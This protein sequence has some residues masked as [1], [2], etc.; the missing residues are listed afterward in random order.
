MFRREIH[1]RA[2]VKVCKGH[3]F[4]VKRDKK[5][6]RCFEWILKKHVRPP[7]QNDAKWPRWWGSVY[8]CHWSISPNVRAKRTAAATTDCDSGS[9]RSYP[10]R[11][12]NTYTKRAPFT[13]TAT[14]DIAAPGVGW[15]FVSTEIPMRQCHSLYAP[16]ARWLGY[17]WTSRVHA[18][19]GGGKGKCTDLAVKFLFTSRCAQSRRFARTSRL[20]RRVA[21]R[22]IR[23]Y[24]LCRS[25]G[26]DGMKEIIYIFEISIRSIGATKNYWCNWAIRC[27]FSRHSQLKCAKSWVKTSVLVWNSNCHAFISFGKQVTSQS[28]GNTASVTSISKSKVRWKKVKKA[29]RATNRTES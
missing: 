19:Q 8:A 18:F 5:L 24:Q 6:R 12:V 4:T 20:W 16:Y 2:R 23:A 3:S 13:T 25:L 7:R 15:H 29:Q 10:F 17:F 9:M 28:D 22:T 11:W 14:G 1:R 21:S 26:S 27:T